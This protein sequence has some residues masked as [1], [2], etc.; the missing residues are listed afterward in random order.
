MQDTAIKGN[1]PVK[2]PV[3]P[4]PSPSPAPDVKKRGGF[5]Y[6][7]LLFCA[8]LRITVVLF[9]LAFA[10]VFFGTWA[11]VDSGIWTVVTK[12]FRGW[13]FTWI[14]LKIILLRTFDIPDS[15]AIP[16]PRGFT[17]GSLLLINLLAAHA[18][19]FKFT[20]RRSGILL[21]HS[22]IV[23]MM[24]GEFV[25]GEFAIEGRMV[26]F[27]GHAANF[28]DSDRKVEL[29]IVRQTDPA[30]DDEIVVPGTLLASAKS[31]QDAEL[32]FDIEVMAY[33]PNSD[34]RPP[35]NNEKS[36]AT[37]GIG[38][39]ELAVPMKE[40]TGVDQNQAVEA[41]AAYIN[42]RKKGTGE[43]LGTYLVSTALYT[44]QR[45]PETVVADGK[46]YQIYLRPQR[47]Y[48]PYTLALKKFDHDVY[49]GTDT[50]RNFSSDLNLLDPGQKRIEKSKSG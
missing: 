40:T 33:M 39:R 24:I 28:V 46:E 16:F 50:P 49:P 20:W 10:L 14:P 32:P 22:G 3:A 26:I 5:L 23:L 18:V 31:I 29:A 21:L 45:P 9:L 11:Q 48:R 41:P 37:V 34:L 43:D 35:R 38:L 12:Y 44:L 36:L 7:I 4:V 25:T 1:L 17:I 47:S 42:F 27:E 30:K 8:S 19:R 6:Q 15:L 13:G 2:P